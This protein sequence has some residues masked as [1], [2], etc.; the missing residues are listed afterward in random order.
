MTVSIF[1][2]TVHILEILPV[3]SKP[4][5]HKLILYFG[6]ELFKCSKMRDQPF[7]LTTKF[8][9]KNHSPE[10]FQKIHT[11]AKIRTSQEGSKGPY[12]ITW[13]R[14]NFRMVFLCKNKVTPN[15]CF[16]LEKQ[17]NL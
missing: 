2:Q 3:I 4:E 8:L 9:S 12:S 14:T 11:V 13:H 10:S 17:T 7:I 15:V 1:N 6:S 5:F 16:V